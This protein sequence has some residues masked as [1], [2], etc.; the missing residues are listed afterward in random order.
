M[1]RKVDPELAKAAL[2]LDLP[3]VGAYAE[4]ARIYPMKGS[5]AQVLGFAGV[6]NK[7]L[8]GIELQ[9]DKELSGEAGSEVVVRDPAG[10]TL[11]TVRQTQP[12]SGADVRLTI[13]EDIQYTA[14]DVLA[15]T[16]R[17][18]G[19]KAAVAIVMDPRTGEVLAMANVP[20]VKDNVFG[21]DPAA[22]SQP[23]RHRRLRARLDLQAR[24]D[25][26]RAGRRPGAADDAS[27]RCRPRCGW[28]TAPST[29][30]RRAAPS[31]SRCARSSSSRATSAP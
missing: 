27:S 9:Y 3:G 17:S 12:V 21:R 13:D 2:A 19:A 14:E 25:L 28:R 6:D 4:E 26:G 23:R 8:A 24:H 31:P 30:R 1:A 22:R 5:A 20:R 18:S 15:R 16:V 7:G 11:R 10:R 29:S